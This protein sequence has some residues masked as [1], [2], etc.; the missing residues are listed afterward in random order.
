MI[1]PEDES[2]IVNID[3]C[4][5]DE[6]VAKMIGWMR[7]PKRLKYL[8]TTQ[9]CIHSDYFEHMP[10]VYGGSILDLIKQ[11]REIARN[12][13]L[14]IAEESIV[15]KDESLKDSLLDSINT[16]DDVI[17]SWDEKLEKAIL[18][19]NAIEKELSKGTYSELQTDE[20]LTQVNGSVH[21]TLISLCDW[22]IKNYGITLIAEPNKF[23]QVSVKP[24]EAQRKDALCIEIENI[25]PNIIRLTPSNVMNALKQKI[26]D[27]KDSKLVESCILGFTSSDGLKWENYNDEI[28][29]TT[30]KALSARLKPYK[31]SRLNQG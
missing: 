22:A 15:C 24:Y 5:K 26:R 29:F 18:Y 4:S 13:L 3:S 7:H 25:L 21:I 9:I 27:P 8:K 19:L 28:K 20:D 6:A 14:D 30:L 16:Q 12:K 17:K 10:T 31:K 2:V 11:Q 23:I 1:N